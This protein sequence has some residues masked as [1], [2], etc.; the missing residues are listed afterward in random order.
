M[1]SIYRKSSPILGVVLALAMSSAA[2]AQNE[3]TGFV[4]TM[5]DQVKWNQ[6]P[7]FLSGGQS[8]VIYGHPNKAGSYYINRVKL[9]AD[10]KV[11]PHSHPDDMV[12]TVLSGTFYIGF[13]D[14]M[15]EAKLKA[16]PVGASFVV[17]ANTNHFHWMRSGEAVV[18]ISGV[19]PSGL[20]YVDHADDPRKK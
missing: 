13:G 8:A 7:A 9:P 11:A 10:F 14:K 4:Q 16:F 12:Y 19:G 18:Q 17:P 15:D 6:N 20:S 5:P 2:F 1:K 3:P